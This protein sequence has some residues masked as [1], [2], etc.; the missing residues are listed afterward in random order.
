MR[1]NVRPSDR[2]KK[3]RSG[4][5]WYHFGQKTPCRVKASVVECAGCGKTFVQC[6][7]KRND[8][9]PVRHCSRTCGLR[10][11][12][13][14]GYNSAGWRGEKSRHWKGGR[15]VRAGYVFINQ[16]E[17]PSCQGN[18]RRYVAEH[19]LVMEAHLGRFLASHETVHHK[20]GIK[21]DNRLENLELWTVGQPA[22]QRVNEQKHCPTCTCGSKHE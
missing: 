5:W 15:Q 14:K 6:P 2:F 3:D 21:T 13:A 17:H 10:S 4:Q 7:I 8:G 19:R 9:K 20:N 12:Y 16:P 22:G 18:Q 1:I 11:S